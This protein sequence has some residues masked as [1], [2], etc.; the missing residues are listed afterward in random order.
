MD[1]V[2]H[3]EKDDGGA[4]VVPPQLVPVVS[5]GN[6]RGNPGL[7]LPVPDYIPA[8]VFLENVGYFTPSSKRIKNIYVKEK[9]LGHKIGPDGAKR[10]IKAKISANHELGLPITSDFDYYRAFLKICDE[11]ADRQGRLY[12][13]IAVPTK[14]LIRYAGKKEN[15]RELKQVR[16]WLARLRHTAIR[17]GTYNAK[18]KDYDERI[19]AGVFSQVII[20]GEKMKDGRIAD[21]NY[22]WL[23]PWFLANYFHHHL[24]PVDLSFHIR[25]RKPIAKALYPLLETGWYASGGTPYS[26]SYHDLSQEFLL[27]EHRP[28]SLVKQQLDPAHRELAREQFLAKWEYR[29]SADKT[30]YVITYYPGEKFFE[31]Q[32]A[33]EERR[34]CAERI[35]R[36][37]EQSP[38]HCPTAN[39][40]GSQEEDKARRELLVRDILD[41]TG[42]PQSKGFYSLV[43]QRLDP[44][45]VYR[46]LSETKEASRAGEIRTNRARYF[47]DLIKR[48]AAERGIAL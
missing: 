36:G 18:R 3:E 7:P 42:D 41:V 21:T 46:A 30:D 2:A 19:E 47:T 31:D 38:A 33:R 4:R 6:H 9:V 8:E 28:L 22:V 25:L 27:T 14:K 1:E 5:Q 17:G 48:Y 16:E 35:A 26:K 12:M 29:E 23:A 24:R 43:A 34:Q 10:T 44:Q 39:G 37:R 20:K 32:D 11:V 40:H 45:T 13:P 15:A